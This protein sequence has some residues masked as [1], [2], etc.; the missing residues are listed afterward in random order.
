MVMRVKENL[1]INALDREDSLQ[2]DQYY[3][4]ISDGQY[5]MA[6]TYSDMNIPVLRS[7]GNVC[8]S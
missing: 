4:A 2:Q 1:C 6:H 5:G 8:V 7:F 3:L